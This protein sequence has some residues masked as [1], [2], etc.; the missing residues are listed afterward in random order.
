MDTNTQQ[1]N[2]GH[3]SEA[4]D[5]AKS[6]LVRHGLGRWETQTIRLA[7]QGAVCSDLRDLHVGGQRAG[8]EIGG[9][10]SNLEPSFG[11]RLSLYWNA[12]ML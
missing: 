9:V 12:T 5:L 11:Q 8:K 6:R 2:T 10:G 4:H 7:D 1:R 3:K